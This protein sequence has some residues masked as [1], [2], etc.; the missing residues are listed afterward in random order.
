VGFDI[1][2]LE[3]YIVNLSACKERSIICKSDEV[4]N[5][6]Y[7]RIEDEILIVMKPKPHSENVSE[8]EIEKSPNLR[9]PCISAP[10]GFIFRIESGS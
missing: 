3:D 10:I 8:S 6:I 4:R 2:C 5:E 1:P 9:H 7:H